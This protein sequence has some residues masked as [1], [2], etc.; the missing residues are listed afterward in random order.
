MWGDPNNPLDW[1]TKC[2]DLPK[3]ED[4]LVV[5]NPADG[6]RWLNCQGYFN[7]QQQ[8]PADQESSDVERR[9]LWYI[10]TGYLIRTDE[11]PSF[12]KW[13]QGVDFMGRW[14]PEA[15]EVYRI[16]LGEHLWAQASLYFQKHYYGDDGW[17]QPNQGCPVK[18][19]TVA[20]EYLCESH[21]FDCS[22][23][24]GYSLRL[25]V[26]ELI[27]GLRIRWNA[28][29]ADFVDLAGRVAVQDPTV[30]AEGPSAL[31]LRED[32]LQEFLARENLT[33]CWAVFGE[34][35]VLPSRSGNSPHFPY[36]RM[37]GA[38]ALSAGKLTGFF[39]PKLDG[40]KS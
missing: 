13:A 34:K 8:P 15:A 27:T 26:S 35:Q 7:W 37:S 9:E 14:M 10:C 6:T 32:L 30:K 31:L 36:L 22:V 33:I 1:V 24:E 28:S 11:A 38:Y 12:L 17:T 25:P 20:F 2:D 21:G 39:T 18:I 23:D 3:V 40:L 4:L 16:F 19:R 5:T 29:G